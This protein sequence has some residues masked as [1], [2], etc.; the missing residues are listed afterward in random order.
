MRAGGA[1]AVLRVGDWVT[2]DDGHYQVVALAGTAVRLRS[3]GG[4]ESMVLAAYLMAA[5]DFAVVGAE[6]LPALEPSGLLETLPETARAAA[7]EWE[8]H[9]VEVETG[10][11]SGAEPGTLPR[12]EYAPATRSLTERMQAK[13]AELGVS[14]R[15]ARPP[16]EQRHLNREAARCLPQHHRSAGSGW[17]LRCFGGGDVDFGRAEDASVGLDLDAVRAGVDRADREAFEPVP[18]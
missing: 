12:H 3:S 11:P 1:G 9:V 6:P 13:A 17:A 4:V 10:L 15:T 5:P 14:W 7:V 8:R 2:F 18:A 16:G